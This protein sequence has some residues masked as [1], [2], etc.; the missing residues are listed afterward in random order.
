MN[1]GQTPTTVSPK[2]P[3]TTTT[4]PPLAPT[5]DTFTATPL[6]E[7][8][9]CAPAQWGTRLAW[10]TTHATTATISATTVT[11]VSGLAPDGSRTIC[12]P[13]PGNP[14]GGWKLTASGPG[15]SA[16]ASA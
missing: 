15:G 3:T 2:P 14:P 13:T 1:P 6:G 4:S 8:G 9:S 7:G 16:T 10:T 12:R 11:T 5:I